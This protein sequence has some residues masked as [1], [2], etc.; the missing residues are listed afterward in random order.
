MAGIEGVGGSSR[1]QGSSSKDLRRR[2]SARQ[3]GT[4]VDGHGLRPRGAFCQ[5]PAGKTFAEGRDGGGF[6]GDTSRFRATETALSRVSGGKAAGSKGLFPHCRE[7]GFVQDWV[8]G[9]VGLKLA[10]NRL[11]AAS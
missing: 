1:L 11:W 10:T 8:V 3:P 4:E 9:L 2:P 5:R 6:F 7:T